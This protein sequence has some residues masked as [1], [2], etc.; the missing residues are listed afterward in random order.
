MKLYFQSSL[1][2]A[3][4]LGLVA[5]GCNLSNNSESE[6]IPTRPNIVLIL[7]DDLGYGDL[8]C[9]GQKIIETP[10][11][12]QLASEGMLFTQ[13]YSAAPVCAP[14]RCML[15][16]GLNSG[17][18]Q[19]RG[20]D[21]MRER[22]DVRDYLAM[23]AD[24]SLEG[25]RPLK[26]GTF[27]LGSMLKSI[28]YKTGAVGKWGLGAPNTDG[29]PNK[30]GFDFFYGYNCQR[31]AHTYFPLH[32]YKNDHR[33]YL[34]ND[35]VAPHKGLPKGADPYDPEIYKPYCLQEYSPDL[36]FT[37]ITQFVNENKDNP[38][39]LY[40]ATP[41][42]HLPLQAPKEWVDHYV[43]KMGPEE[44]YVG[45]LK[46]GGYFPNLYPRATYAGM[47]SYLDNQIGE[48]IQQLKDL[49]IYENTLIFFTSDN[50]PV[51]FYTKAFQSAAPFRTEDGFMKGTL[52]EGGIR[53]PL[54]AHWP[55]VI[56]PGT[57]SDHISAFY[58]IMPTL[59]EITQTKIT[60]DISGINF[61]PILI[62]KKQNT[63]EYLYWEFPERNGQV[64]VRIGNMKALGI[65]LKATDSIEWQLFDLS[66]DVQELNDIA[67]EHP[68]IIAKVN[69]FVRKEHVETPV[70]SWKLK[71]LDK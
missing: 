13:F 34:S 50:G 31:Q 35:T 43:K 68:E 19:I 40:W 45:T 61:L 54:I 38:F 52:Y 30:Q 42:P 32:L 66:K 7:A 14:A 49:G 51:G 47:I 5:G 56:K 37:E 9:Y 1:Q 29:I 4:I 36:M 63:H 3:C 67:L 8:G 18:S 17:R 16:T 26:P 48:L 53:V 27:T 46:R 44:P 11:L 71:L 65:N 24:S 58:D 64:A 10:N 39:F 41:I 59:A 62:G 28:G 12:D 25:Q 57:Q 69:E 23:L 60:E 33:V 22:G 21:E 70:D 15:L 2:K 55:G 20:N 6:N